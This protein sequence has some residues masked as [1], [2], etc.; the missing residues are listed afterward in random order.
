M[1]VVW[2][3]GEN[4]AYRLETVPNE[5]GVKESDKYAR[6][7]RSTIWPMTWDMIKDHPCWGRI[8]K[9]LDGDY[10]VPSGFWQADSPGSP[11]RLSGIVG[12]RE[13][14]LGPH[15]WYGSSLF[16][17]ESWLFGRAILA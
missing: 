3:G 9:L 16:S 17:F 15:L 2:V 14:S 7:N 11:Q 13:V 12:E 6:T 5:F 4:L 10:Q 8:W 1:G